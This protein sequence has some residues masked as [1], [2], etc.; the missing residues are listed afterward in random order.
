MVHLLVSS[1]ALLFERNILSPP[2]K[3]GLIKLVFI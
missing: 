3:G 1:P 2:T